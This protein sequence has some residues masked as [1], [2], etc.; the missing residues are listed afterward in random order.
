M[1]NGNT[2]TFGASSVSDPDD[3]KAAPITFIRA[4]RKIASFQRSEVVGWLLLEE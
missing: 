3:D 4:G 1:R 2:F